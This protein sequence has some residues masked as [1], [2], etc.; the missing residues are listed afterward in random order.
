M[1]RIRFAIFC[2]VP[3]A[4]LFFSYPAPAWVRAAEAPIVLGV[5]LSTAYLYGRSAQRG[6]RLAVDEINAATDTDTDKN[7]LFDS[8]SI[9]KY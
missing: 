2:L 3:V 6:I 4:M 9:E 7:L 5:P 1:K 8:R